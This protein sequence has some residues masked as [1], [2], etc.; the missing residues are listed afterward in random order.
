MNDVPLVK[1]NN[2]NDI[3][4]S[5]IAIKKQL[6]QLNEALGLI[7]VPNA[8]DLSPYVR[9]DEVVDIVESGNMNPVTSNAVVP[10]DEVTSGNMHSVTSNAVA[11]RLKVSDELLILDDS[12]AKVTLRYFDKV[13]LFSAMAK[14]AISGYKSI[15]I[16][17]YEC[18]TGQYYKSALTWGGQT[19]GEFALQSDGKHLEITSSGQASGSLIL[20]LK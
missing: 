3:N 17:N 19:K 7:D 15:D 12:N 20:F 2:V 8:P 4:T 6:K 9:K 11:E 1:D 14:S 10:V 16:T 18:Y 13:A 5:I